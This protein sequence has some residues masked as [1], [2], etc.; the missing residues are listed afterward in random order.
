MTHCLGHMTRC[1]VRV[2]DE[3]GGEET[4]NRGNVVP[5]VNIAHAT[6]GVCSTV[7]SQVNSTPS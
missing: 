2:E 5:E 6:H 1:L 7:Y 4:Q 3:V